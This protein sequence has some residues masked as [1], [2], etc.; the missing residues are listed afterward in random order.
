LS[1]G[2]PCIASR[3]GALPEVG[4]DFVDYIDPW[5]LDD[6]VSVFRRM[7]ED[8]TY[9]AE[10][11]QAIRAHFAPRS[12]QDVGKE[13][14]AAIAGRLATSRLSRSIPPV[15][16]REGVLFDPGVAQA[17]VVPTDDQFGN[18]MSVALAASFYEA[19]P[20]GAWLRGGTGELTF[21]TTAAAGEAIVLFLR[22]GAAPWAAGGLFS[23]SLATSR[24]V[25]RWMVLSG[26][27]DD[28]IRVEGTTC[29]E[30]LCTI[31]FAYDG[32]LQIPRDDFR[33]IGVSLKAIGY[34]RKSAVHS[35]LD[36]REQFLFEAAA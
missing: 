19:E 22:V 17:S 14:M 25:R 16:L 6:G 29:S 34:A 26:G 7:I 23:V 21:R 10:R 9:R 18:P 11:R 5:D 12:W 15:N 13:V 35:R 36:L 3:A 20:N 32:D 31:I 2:V 24:S 28:L 30:G 8:D 33:H 27:D 4:G 1:R